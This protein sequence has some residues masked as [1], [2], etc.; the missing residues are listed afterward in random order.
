MSKCPHNAYPLDMNAEF[1][2]GLVVARS[3]C[4][5]VCGGFPVSISGADDQLSRNCTWAIPSGVTNLISCNP[6]KQTR[7]F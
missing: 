5:Y 3:L 7:E 2:I 4:V 6:Q 1:A